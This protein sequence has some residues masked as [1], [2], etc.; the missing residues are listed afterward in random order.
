MKIIY[1]SVICHFPRHGCVHQNSWNQKNPIFGFSLSVMP[2]VLYHIWFSQISDKKNE[3]TVPLLTKSN[4]WDKP[5][6][7]ITKSSPI[8]KFLV[9][10][11]IHFVRSFWGVHFLSNFQG[12]HNSRTKV[13]SPFWNTLFCCPF[14]YEM[15]KMLIFF[16]PFFYR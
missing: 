5:T 10:K 2:P 3:K 8:A 16:F 15:M 13:G 9:F 11:I 1:S 4:F 7:M 14:K 12:V 6:L